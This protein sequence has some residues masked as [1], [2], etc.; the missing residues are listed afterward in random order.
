MNTSEPGTTMKDQIP[1]RPGLGQWLI[2]LALT[3]WLAV[4]PLLV[5]AVLQ[6]TTY[7]VPDILVDLGVLAPHDPTL[8][9]WAFGLL[10]TALT[11]ML[12]LAA[13][14]PLYFATRKPGREF[15]H[16][17]SS[18]LVAI[19]LFQVLMALPSLLWPQGEPIP[20]MTNRTLA[21]AARLVLG[22]L[23]TLLGMGWIE[24]QH[25]GGSLIKA[26]RRVGLRLWLVPSAL[27]LA[28]AAGTVIVFPWVLVG[29]LGSAGTTAANF[30]QALPDA[31]NQE[32]LFRGIAFAWLWRAARGRTAAAI[33]SLLLFAAAQ[34]A[35]VLPTGDWGASLRFV[36]ALLL[37]LLLTELTVR[38]SGSIWPAVTVHLMFTWFPLA[39]ADPRSEE[40]IL[41]WLVQIW[42]PLAAGGIG[43]LLWLARK[44]TA[45]IAPG[46]PSPVPGG[47]WGTVASAGLAC[48]AWLATI[49]L[50]VTLGA[51]GFHPDGF[52]I[53][54]EEQADLSPAA[55]I[56]DPVDRRAWVYQTLV[57]TAERTQTPL[58]AELDRRGVTYR[59]HYLIN[60]VEVQ[61][62]PGLRHAFAREP[63]VA[64]VLFQ[65]GM[66][67]YP[68]SFVMPN[69]DPTG[70]TGVEW[71]VRDVGADQVWDLG[72]TG[73]GIVVGDADTGVAWD[74]PALKAAYLGWD[75]QTVSH[76]YHWY[77]PWDGR[78]EPWDD[79]GHGTHTTGTV[80]GL[81]GE[82][83]IG[84]APGAQWIACRNMRHGLGNPGSY[85]SCM[86]FLLAPFPLGGDP[87][88]DG[89]PSRGAHIVNN[90]WGCPEREGCHPETLRVAAENLRAAGQMMVVSAGNEGPACGTVQ[91][92]LAL[93]DAVFS[94]G[95]IQR[96]DKAANF[97]SRG[98][99][100]VD[101]SGR[102]KPDIVAP[103][104]D[105]RSSVP[106]GYM[107]SGGTSMAGPHVAGAAVLLWSADP[108]LIGDVER[109]E[110]LLVETAQPLRVD[111][112]CRDDGTDQMGTVCG[113]ADD[114]PASVPNQVYGWGQVDV[115]GAMQKLQAGQ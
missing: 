90:S 3:L 71:N 109:T 37:G 62:R 60:V 28:L 30:L 100:A 87:L 46:R 15:L 73:Q 14:V 101:G 38:A 9:A 84:M 67:R 24:A 23:F 16:T 49:L 80:V 44:V 52:L 112:G 34:G 108:T 106:G 78:T 11:L 76:D 53:F 81:D 93:Y 5:T 55:S 6:A 82:N 89:D 31:L 12:D 1:D 75:G 104:V 74:H 10:S 18:L 68:H 26:W 64:S 50:Y 83:Q 97:S 77:D 8:P 88:H 25:H 39:F 57:E 70:P 63:G 91:D 19:S 58:W 20:P 85:V 35:T 96:D 33:G 56:A 40:E 32:I 110:G 2:F 102:A 113:C 13:F 4:V 51:P 115:W 92:P 41:H 66:R 107:I 7:H 21:A 94:V 72:Y 95:A 65:P 48:L 45:R 27:W 114:E 29:S 17:L 36:P 54:M 103:G 59:P 22:L 47:R 43:L 69:V 42:M 98:P 79:H 111:A 105:I 61:G 99:V 86:E